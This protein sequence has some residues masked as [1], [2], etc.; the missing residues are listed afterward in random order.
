MKLIVAALDAFHFDVAEDEQMNDVEENIDD[1]EVQSDDEK[2]NERVVESEEQRGAVSVHKQMTKTVLPM[3]HE[4]LKVRSTKEAGD[5]VT[6]L[7]VRDES[8]MTVH[9]KLALQADGR[10][11]QHAL[12]DA[13][14]L[15]VTIALALVKLLHRVSEPLLHVQLPGYV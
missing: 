11:M 13:Q 8:R 15:R 14:T 1:E 3:L 2:K 10:E 6:L 9:T 5:K 12:E 7:Q 4:V